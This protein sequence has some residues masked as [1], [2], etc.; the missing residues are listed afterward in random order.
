MVDN[1]PRTPQVAVGAILI[2]NDKILLVKRMKD[3]HRGEWA[4]PGGSLKL[5][6]TLQEAAE[7]EIREETGL[8]I[9]P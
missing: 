1:F 4:I 6:E 8:L 5:G 9:I 3:P 2:S 7:R